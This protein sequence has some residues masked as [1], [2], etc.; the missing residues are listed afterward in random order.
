M[1]IDITDLRP[2][3]VPKSDQLNAEQLLGGAMAITV[4]N[5]RVGGGEEQPISIHYENDSGR[6]YK[7]CKTMRKVLILAWGHDATQWVGR[8]MMLYN[9]PA[10]KY[11]GMEV[12]GIRIS[13]LSDIERDIKVALTAT[14]GKK[15]P[16]IIG[17]MP[18]QQDQHAAAI[19]GSPTLE[20]LESAFKA[21]IR[22]TRDP[23]KRTEYT[24]RKDDRKKALLANSATAKTLAQYK[25]DIDNAGDAAIAQ[26][27]MDEARDVLAPHEME[28]LQK[29]YAMAWG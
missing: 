26:L 17:Y 14:R 19:E 25:D 5:V 27:V 11:G 10:V 21:A 4:T 18:R 28:D 9:D 15:A 7:P 22:S 12:G 1:S 6:P 23:A 29:A 2:T 13:H 8:S 16:H 24:E 20:A 3:I